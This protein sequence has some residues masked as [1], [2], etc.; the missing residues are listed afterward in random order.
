MNPL[1][2][3]YAHVYVCVNMR[4]W[5]CA[6]TTVLCGCKILDECV[7]VVN[8]WINRISVFKLSKN[9]LPRCSQTNV[10]PIH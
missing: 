10:V 8:L 5:V 1:T 3:K 9:F 4:G 6:H 7:F 2:Y